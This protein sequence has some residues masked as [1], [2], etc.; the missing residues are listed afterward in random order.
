ME[1]AENPCSTLCRVHVQ[2]I[3]ITS[4]LSHDML[5]DISVTVMSSSGLDDW[6]SIP[7]NGRNFSLR[8]YV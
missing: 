8:H 1:K 4:D 3:R 6:N 7:G 5:W 2:S